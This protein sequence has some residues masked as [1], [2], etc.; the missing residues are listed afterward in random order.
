MVDFFLFNDHMWIRYTRESNFLTNKHNAVQG[1]KDG[2]KNVF[3]ELYDYEATCV[4]VSGLDY[5][6]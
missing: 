2:A 4:C 3:G 6:L 5:F 1:D